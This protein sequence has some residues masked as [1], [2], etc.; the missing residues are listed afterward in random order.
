MILGLCLNGSLMVRNKVVP[1]DAVLSVLL[2]SF[3][4]PKFQLNVDIFTELH[5]ALD[6]LG[7]L[8]PAN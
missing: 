8:K 3:M 2:A 6:L 1:K 7:F 5:L 4:L